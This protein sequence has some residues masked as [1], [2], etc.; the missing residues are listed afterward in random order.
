MNFTTGS[1]SLHIQPISSPSRSLRFGWTATTGTMIIPS[2]NRC[3]ELVRHGDE[4]DVWLV[5]HSE[6][7]VHT[8]V[9][10]RNE[11]RKVGEDTFWPWGSWNKIV[12]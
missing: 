4:A 3:G 9:N 12:G 8:L 6:G 11:E 1:I 2:P 10:E 7:Q 5:K